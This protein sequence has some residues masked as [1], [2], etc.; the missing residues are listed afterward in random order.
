MN[1]VIVSALAALLFFTG[2]SD[3]KAQSSELSS[4]E[5]EVME[6]VFRL[7][8]GMRQGDSSMVSSVF[9]D[10]VRMYTVFGPD[11]DNQ[12][13]VDNVDGFLKAVGT[14]HETVWDEPIWDYTIQID[15]NL[16]HVW[17]KYAFYAGDKF[18]HCGVDDFQFVKTADGWKVFSLADTR[19]YTDC[20]L[21]PTD[22]MERGF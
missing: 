7:F 20:D 2:Q 22:Q 4:Q 1:Y 15:G 10:D 21:P 11:R 19:Q 14:P 13:K 18:S 12:F 6:V 16:A 5:A 9:T 8:E 17:T 3:V